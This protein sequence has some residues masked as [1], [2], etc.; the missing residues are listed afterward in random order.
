MTT[1]IRAKTILTLDGKDHIY[2]PGFLIIE[3]DR[4]TE[5]GQSDQLDSSHH[6]DKTID[7]DDRL[8]MPGLINAH[9]HSPMV[10]FRGMA[11]GHSLFT[12]DG[13]FNT[14]RVVE[15]VME[16]GYAACGRNSFLR[17][18]DPHRNHL[19]CGSI[20]LDGPHRATG[21]EKQN[22]SSSLLW[23]RGTG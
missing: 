21:A 6:F 20:F 18:D 7:L 11:E 23:N 15:Q 3:N 9:T 14:V 19:L 10:L 13:W 5:V 1:L 12:F 16:P 2:Q 8:L 17:R 4:I 22:A